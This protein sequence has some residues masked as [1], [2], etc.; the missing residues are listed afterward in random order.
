MAEAGLSPLEI[1]TQSGHRN[2]GILLGY[3]QHCP[4]RIRQSYKGVFDDTKGIEAANGW[5]RIY[6]GAE[7]FKKL[8]IEEYL[9][10]EIGT[11]TLHTLLQSPDERS[12]KR[13]HLLTYP[14]PRIPI[15]SPYFWVN[16][17]FYQSF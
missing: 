1:Q 15:I 2:I 12:P 16:D 8:A 6:F 3:I 4:E 11:D 17:G 13:A 7:S 10:G 14:T 5:D 9:T